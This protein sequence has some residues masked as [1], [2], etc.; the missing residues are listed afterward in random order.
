M[1]LRFVIGRAGSGKTK[2]CFDAIVSAMRERPLGEPIYWILPKQATF[3]AERELTTLG[4]LAGFCR[5]RVLS[6]DLLGDEVL[7]SPAAAAAAT[8]VSALGR[9]MLLG[10]L[11][12][13]HQDKLRYFRSVARQPGLAARLDATFA[14]F[15]RSGKDADALE[16]LLH[17]LSVPSDDAERDLL[18]EKVADFHLLY[19][20]YRDAL[21]Q[22][23]VDPHRRLE[24]V[25]K[26]M[27]DHVPLHGATVFIDGFLEFT[28]RERQI[29]AALA[30]TCASVDVT[31]LIDPASPTLKNL[32]HLPGEL[33][34]FFRT[35][36]TLIGSL[37]W[38]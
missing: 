8:E 11:L 16:A 31:L 9:Q 29:I 35:E 1:G 4:G 10:F 21:G 6:F 27:A 15:E 33:D 23:L 2:H 13:K 36:M 25:L 18:R 3:S 30:K 19:R 37:R 20:A 28:D 32:H 24:L 5:A 22:E 26:C 17:E 7:G 12:R 34:L 14:E 38:R